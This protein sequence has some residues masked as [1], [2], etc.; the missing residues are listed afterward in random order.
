MLHDYVETPSFGFL[1]LYFAISEQKRCI[2]QRGV[3]ELCSNDGGCSLF[4]LSLVAQTHCGVHSVS[5]TH[6]NGHLDISVTVKQSKRTPEPLKHQIYWV[7]V[8]WYYNRLIKWELRHYIAKGNLARKIKNKLDLSL[9]KYVDIHFENVT[10][11]YK[12][13]CLL[14]IR[15]LLF[16]DG[17]PG[18]N[19]TVYN[20]LFSKRL[21]NGCNF[22][23]R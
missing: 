8:K 19:I 11:K 1:A 20:K 13:W 9:N 18:L 10:I 16:V 2:L 17:L 21:V 14:L 22:S 3:A 5:K 6:L 7:S 12:T 23:Y 4:T 15:M